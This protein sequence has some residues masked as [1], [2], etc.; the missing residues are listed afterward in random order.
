MGNIF[1]D[2]YSQ[3][4]LCIANI[5]TQLI[6]TWKNFDQPEV[7]WLLKLTSTL[8]SKMHWSSEL[9]VQ[10]EWNTNFRLLSS[11]QLKYEGSS[12]WWPA[13]CSKSSPLSSSSPAAPLLPG[14]CGHCDLD[15]EAQKHS[16]SGGTGGA[17]HLLMTQFS[18]HPSVLAA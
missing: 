2:N 18:F 9:F 1:E 6:P 7:D 12:E 8:R 5:S 3:K 13:Q 11:G 16:F 14:H 10:L 17:L 15:N 4:K